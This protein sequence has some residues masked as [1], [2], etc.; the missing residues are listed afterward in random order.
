MDCKNN[1]DKSF[2]LTKLVLDIL[3]RFIWNI[4]ALLHIGL[5][6]RKANKEKLMKIVILRI[7]SIGMVA[8][9]GIISI[10][11]IGGNKRTISINSEMNTCKINIDLDFDVLFYMSI[12]FIFTAQAKTQQKY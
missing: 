10:I 9:I 12:I 1:A 11:K 2:I 5:K 3:I 7:G 8:N 6:T 4:I